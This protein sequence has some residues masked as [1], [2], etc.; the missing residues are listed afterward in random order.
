[1]TR[2]NAKCKCACGFTQEHQDR[3][4]V[5]GNG[6]RVPQDV[7][8]I[9]CIWENGDRTGAVCSQQHRLCVRMRAGFRPS[10]E[11]PTVGLRRD[12]TLDG[13]AAFFRRTPPKVPYSTSLVLGAQPVGRGWWN[14]ESSRRRRQR[15][16]GPCTFQL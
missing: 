5:Y 10:R 6:I 4:V 15:K 14:A 8:C 9:H 3:K 11:K 2:Q 7:V 12:G 16:C 13:H 1:M